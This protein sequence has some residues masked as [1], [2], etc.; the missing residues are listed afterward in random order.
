MRLD[1][2]AMT[3]AQA[4]Q[5]AL[6][7]ASELNHG[8]VEPLHLLHVL[9]SENENNLDA[10]IRRI[11]ADPK[12]V[13]KNVDNELQKMPKVTS[14]AYAMMP[15]PSPA[16]MKVFDE[17]VKAAE[18]LGDEYAT[19][20]HLLIALADSNDT[21]GKVLNMAGITRKNVEKVYEDLR[22][23]TRVT[24][25]DSKT[26]FEALEKYGQ[27]LTNMAREGK[28]DPV[29]GRSEEIRRTIQVLSRRTKNNPCLIGEPPASSS[30]PNLSK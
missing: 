16:F 3:S 20:E 6:S 8:S 28:L 7:Y 18:K 14:S 10:I 23:D 22:G 29:I 19:T 25:Q 2:L 30:P 21:A 12:Q 1:K 11:G 9:L 15:N 26:E 27:N 17:A 4:M 24:E 5:S 13:L